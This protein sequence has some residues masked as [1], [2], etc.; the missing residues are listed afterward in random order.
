MW[1]ITLSLCLYGFILTL[2]SAIISRL[3]NGV[4]WS[5]LF[6]TRFYELNSVR[7]IIWVTQALIASVC[8]SSSFL[9]VTQVEMLYR[10]DILLTS[11][12]I[13]ITPFIFTTISSIIICRYTWL[14]FTKVIQTPENPS[15]SMIGACFV[16]NINESEFDRLGTERY[17]NNISPDQVIDNQ[18]RI[19]IIVLCI[20]LAS[21]LLFEYF[22][23]EKFIIS[24]FQ[25]IVDLLPHTNINVY[26]FSVFVLWSAIVIMIILLF[27]NYDY[28]FINFCPTLL[29]QSLLAM[30]CLV[31]LSIVTSSG[32]FFIFALIIMS[33]AHGLRAFI[34]LSKC[35]RYRAIKRV[36][37]P[38]VETLRN[39]VPYLDKIPEYQQF[40][41]PT[42][43]EESLI[44]R[45]A[46]GCR[47]VEEHSI[48]VTK[49]IARFIRLLEVRQRNCASA[50]LCYLTVGRYVTLS[51]GHGTYLSFREPEVPQWNLNLFP[52]YPP[53]DYVNKLDPL[54]LGH[55]WDVVRTCCECGGSGRVQR[56]ETYYETEQYTEHYT[57][58]NGRSC[59]RSATRQVAKE[60]KIWVT[61]PSC[62]GSGRLQYQQILNTQWKYFKPTLTFPELS[63]PELVE[64]AEE[65][66]YFHL[67]LTDNFK[68]LIF[69]PNFDNLLEV[70]SNGNSLVRQ[71][72]N[73]VELIVSKHENNSDRVLRLHGNEYLY[74][75]DFKICG[76][77]TICIRFQKL[78]GRI[79][80]FFGK[81]PEFYFP[82]LPISYETVFT[83]VFLPPLII[84]TLIAVIQF[85]LELQVLIQ[86]HQIFDQIAFLKLLDYLKNIVQN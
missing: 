49:F 19:G 56:T 74:R 10:Q 12:T 67:P 59:S 5:D 77:R 31:S 78:G 30:L 42:L 79:G 58:S 52:V 71:V 39:D 32:K 62:S 61:C 21:T 23:D 28:T 11:A 27:T 51:V 37:D 46:Q 60:R 63:M 36:Y 81:R 15:P 55:E 6:K 50:M 72:R 17:P 80:W 38:I 69:K 84:V 44:R 66:T 75:S 47:N 8:I 64:D 85:T 34:D 22:S 76:F 20:I 16:E 18:L 9:L 7:S 65:V 3:T 25:K 86:N 1:N 45:I 2:I 43:D 26:G 82:R 14:N 40:K 48:F 29:I 53:Q 41:L 83:F 33:I 13:Q 35:W 4:A 57:D 73:T 24:E 68:S 70:N 54:G